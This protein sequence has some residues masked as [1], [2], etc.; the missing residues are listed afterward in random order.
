[1]LQLNIVQTMALLVQ[2]LRLCCIA[3]IH[4]QQY[5]G[6]TSV[7][8]YMHSLHLHMVVHAVYC[9]LLS[10]CSDALQ[11]ALCKSVFVALRAYSE[12]RRDIVIAASKARSSRI[13]GACLRSW[14]QHAYRQGVIRTGV[15]TL[16]K[17]MAA[18]EMKSA[19]CGWRQTSVSQLASAAVHN[20]GRLMVRM[21]RA[22]LQRACLERDSLA[23]FRAEATGRVTS[24]ALTGWRQHTQR[25]IAVVA[26]AEGHRSRRRLLSCL[27]AW[28]DCHQTRKALVATLWGRKANVGMA[29]AISAWKE[30]VNASK[31][32][33]TEV[34]TDPASFYL[35]ELL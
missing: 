10:G 11:E 28:R 9:A 13:V 26:A 1:M 4:R 24:A 14:Q 16:H 19:L 25:K 17:S 35:I 2:W 30:Y 34:S 32:Q 5:V 21:F 12:Q 15:Q 3:Y 8:D 23:A 6:C 29:K 18:R 33:Q 7:S 27:E 20:Q 22:W 31:A